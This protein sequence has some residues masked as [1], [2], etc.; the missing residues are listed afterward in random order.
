M[1]PRYFIENIGI[2]QVNIDI[3]KDHLN[4]QINTN[5]SAYVCVTNARTTYLANHNTKYCK[6]QNNS[7]LTIPDGI[8]LVWIAHL[9]GFKDVRRVSGPSLMTNMLDLSGQNNYSHYF[10][11]GSQNV[12]DKI[13]TKLQTKYL[14]VEIKGLI[15]PPFQPVE[16]FDIENL[17]TELNELRPTFFWCGLGAPKQEQLISSLQPYL[18]STICIGVGLAFDYFAGTVFEPPILFRIFKIEWLYRCLQQPV[19][20]RRFIM[21]FFYILRILFKN[22]LQKLYK[23][24]K[25]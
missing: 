14:N 18:K 4:A 10:Y 16:A 25:K 12:I 13:K 11:G 24:L 6:I 2:S 21:P 17:A 9:Q 23:S 8:P 3:V 22:M 1:Y 20:S 15:S 19:K 5:K 7:F